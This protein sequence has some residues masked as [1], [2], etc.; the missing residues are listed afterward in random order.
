MRFMKKRVYAFVLVVMMLAITACASSDEGDF[1]IGTTT[2]T[3]YENEYFGIRYTPTNNMVLQDEAYIKQVNAA[4][5]SMLDDE[6][7]KKSL[8]SGNS[9][10]IAYAV[11]QDSTCTFNIIVQNVK[12]LFQKNVSDDYIIDQSLDPTKELLESMGVFDSVKVTKGTA[13]FL[14]KDVVSMDVEAKVGGY[15]FYET[16]VLLRKGNY[17]MFITVGAYFDKATLQTLLNDVQSIE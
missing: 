10:T 11:N 6:N 14:G 13:N 5:I 1:T 16:E 8:E 17:V 15:D 3:Y 12:S 7:V 9:I 2:E 4:M